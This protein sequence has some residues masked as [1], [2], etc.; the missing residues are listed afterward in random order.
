VNSHSNANV[1]EQFAEKKKGKAIFIARTPQ[2]SD[3]IVKLQLCG[4]SPGEEP[5]IEQDGTSMETLI[6]TMNDKN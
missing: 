5:C 2:S 3:K 4:A 6:V 1:I